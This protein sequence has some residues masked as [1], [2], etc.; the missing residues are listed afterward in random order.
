MSETRRRLL[1]IVPVGLAAVIAIALIGISRSGA[2]TPAP[3]PVGS[4]LAG[5]GMARDL[6]AGIPSHADTLGDPAAKVTIV[7]YADLRCPTCRMFASEV[8]PTVVNDLVRTGKAKLRFRI[9]P[10]LG[11]DSETAA[12]AAYAAQQQ[13]RLWLYADLWYAN[14]LP[15]TQTYATDAFVREIASAAGLDLAR[16]DRDRASPKA[17]EA[18]HLVDQ[19]ATAAGAVGTPT[20]GV[21]GPAGAK[22]LDG[23]PS[24][25]D[26]AAAVQSAA[27]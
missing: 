5:I 11:P 12:L 14:Q 27:G 26:I 19:A 4:D 16:F 13:D 2:R 18:W 15:E 24:A 1:L 9:W 6:V 22:L 8:I 23:V 7:E 10:I 25:G 21:E 20:I 17:V 3:A